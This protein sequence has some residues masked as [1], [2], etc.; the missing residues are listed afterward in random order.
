[1][2]GFNGFPPGKTPHIRVPS[3][4]FS[5]LLPSIDHLAEMK[6]TVYCFWALQRQEGEYKYV[7]LSEIM[8]DEIFMAGLGDTLEK[9]Q[10]ELMEGLER[11]TARGTLLHVTLHLQHESEEIYFMNTVN[12]RNAVKAIESDNWLPGDAKRPIALIIERPNI[13]VVYE[14]NIGSITHR[15]AD[16][17]RSLEDDYPEQWIVDAIYIATENNRRSLRYIEA[18]LERW[19]R[20]GKHGFTGQRS[21]EHDSSE[22]DFSDYIE[23]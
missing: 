11:A 22:E 16:Q 12:G 8:A 1:M 4:F 19:N 18:I 3:L 6:V 17:L 2:K 21:S 14:Q 7:R 10:R 13:F 20:E 15:I 5:E 9:Q 23:R